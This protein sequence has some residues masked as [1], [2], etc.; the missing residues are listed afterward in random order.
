VQRVTRF[1]AGGTSIVKISLNQGC[2]FPAGH[3]QLICE[4]EVEL[5]KD[6]SHDAMTLARQWC[7][8]QGLWISAIAKSVKGQRLGSKAA[9][10]APT[11]AVPK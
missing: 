6:S 11:S 5:K 4:L 9:M 1:E 2:V 10:S 8:N 7:A 3:A